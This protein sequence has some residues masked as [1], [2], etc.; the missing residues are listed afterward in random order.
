M[1]IEEF[2]ILRKWPIAFMIACTAGQIQFWV[3][4]DTQYAFMVLSCIPFSLTDIGLWVLLFLSF[5]SKPWFI[6]IILPVLHET[7]ILTLYLFIIQ[8]KCEYE[9]EGGFT[10]QYSFSVLTNSNFLVQ[11]VI[12]NTGVCMKVLPKS[13]AIY[14]LF[15]MATF[16]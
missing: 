15:I 1:E 7:L 9:K 8:N 16:L 2:K 5:R 6:R 13:R 14:V 4:P 10:S 12:I 3:S 11:C